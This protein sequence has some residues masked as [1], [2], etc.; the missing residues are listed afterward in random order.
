MLLVMIR[1]LFEGVGVFEC[2]EIDVFGIDIETL[3]RW[4]VRITVD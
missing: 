3:G 1:I 4:K 2:I